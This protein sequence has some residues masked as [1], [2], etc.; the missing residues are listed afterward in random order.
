MMIG[1]AKPVNGI[2]AAACMKPTISSP[3]LRVMKAFAE[4][5]VPRQKKAGLERARLKVLAT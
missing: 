4:Q 2:G 3:T 5:R 1:A